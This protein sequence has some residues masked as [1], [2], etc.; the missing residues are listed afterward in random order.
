MYDGNLVKVEDIKVEDKVMGDDSTPRNVVA[1]GRG[2]DKMYD[3]EQKQSEID[4]GSKYTVNSEHILC[5]KYI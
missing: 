5:L 2:K 4:P 1:L 3:I